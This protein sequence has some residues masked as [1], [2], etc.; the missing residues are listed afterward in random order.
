MQIPA[1][2]KPAVYGAGGGA[3][4]LAIIGFTWGGWVTGGRAQKMADSASVTAVA[5]AMT[6]YCVEKSRNDPRSVEVLAEL[7]A[8]QGYNRRGVVEKAGWATLLGTEK[9]NTDLARAC[10]VALAAT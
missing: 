6:P 1:W 8:A 5:D 4:A 10:E 9:P 2:V 7:K 3:V